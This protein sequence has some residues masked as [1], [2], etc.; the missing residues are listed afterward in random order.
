MWFALGFNVLI[1]ISFNLFPEFLVSIFHAK[2]SQGY[3]LVR[4]ITVPL[5]RLTSVW[6]I[7]D[8]VQIVIGSILRATGDTLFMMKLYLIL[9][10]LFY[11]LL[12][13]Y[14]YIIADY[15]LFWVWIELLTYTIVMLLIVTWRYVGGKWRNIE[16]LNNQ[17]VRA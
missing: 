5:I 2:Q 17:S 8:S 7:F 15:S 14:T 16:V 12:P 6:I 9:P 10:I 11:L 1:I 13:Y 4:D 3:D